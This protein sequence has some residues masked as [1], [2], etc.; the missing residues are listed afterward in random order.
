MINKTLLDPKGLSGDKF[1][2]YNQKIAVS[3]VSLAKSPEKGGMPFVFAF[4]STKEHYLDEVKMPHLNKKGDIEFS[5]TAATDGKRYIWSTPFLDVQGPREIAIVTAHETFHMVL[6]H[7]NPHRS[8]GKH[9][10]AWAIAID[11]VVNAMIEHDLV[12]S[13]QISKYDC[14]RARNGENTTHPIWKDGLGGTSG[15]VYFHILMKD[16][17]KSF[18]QLAEDKKKGKKPVKP[19]GNIA[20]NQPKPQVLRPYADD[21]LYGKSAEDIYNDIMKKMEEEANKN[22]LQLGDCLSLADFHLSWGRGDIMDEH[23]E[24]ELPRGKLMEEVMDAIAAAR[25]LAGSVPGSI[26]EELKRLQEPK[27]KWQDLVRHALQTTRQEK[28]SINDWTRMRR[29]FVSKG[30]Y[31][32]KKKDMRVRWLCG[33]DTSGSMSDEDI[34][35]GVSQLKVLDGRSKGIVV[36][37]DAQVYWEHAVEIHC[38]GDLPKIKPIGRGGTCCN[39]LFENYPK[40]LIEEIDLIIMITDGFLFDF[41]LK[42]PS[43]DVVWVITNDHQFN[44]PFG[45]VAPLRA[46]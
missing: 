36:P 30:M 31:T 13:N 9:K 15:P 37:W 38:M 24:I 7:C 5:Y 2:S 33:L 22:G 17:E 44:A 10:A 6:Q 35:Y 39:E 26:E 12:N 8:F 32:P 41:E 18:K 23:Q 21:Q 16:I 45:R 34:V 43:C 4:T 14:E 1:E 40:H 20:E 27:L 25:Q 3:K 42:K 28:G 19:T 11:Y 29:R 46:Y